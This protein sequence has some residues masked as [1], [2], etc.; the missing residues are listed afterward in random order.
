MKTTIT[1]PANS[2][3][4]DKLIEAMNSGKTIMFEHGGRKY[5]D[6]FVS[7][8]EF[9]G[10]NEGVEY[11]VEIKDGLG[12]IFSNIERQVAAS[13]PIINTGRRCGKT[14]MKAAKMR[15]F[16]EMYGAGPETIKRHLPQ[17]KQKGDDMVTKWQF[18]SLHPSDIDFDDI[19][20]GLT[21]KNPLALV[22]GD[23]KDGVVDEDYVVIH[24]YL[25]TKSRLAGIKC[26]AEDS[27]I[28][29]PI[30]VMSNRRRVY[31]SFV[32]EFQLWVDWAKRVK[33]ASWESD[34]RRRVL[35]TVTLPK[36]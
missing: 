30:L 20:A 19:A 8:V 32:Q 16:L 1:L 28:P 21:R 9:H 22:K 2:P 35:F 4:I 17:L 15:R 27:G 13:F 6:C 3:M 14:E 26:P 18:K 24:P 36:V 34:D 10:S 11:R 5:N 23:V 12:I 7:K 25:W 33:G 29:S 31:S